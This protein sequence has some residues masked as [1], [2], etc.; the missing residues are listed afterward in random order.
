M[1][2]SGMEVIRVD[3]HLH[4]K[5]DK[6]FKYNGD[7]NSF[8]KDYVRKLQ[9]SNIKMTFPPKTSPVFKL[10]YIYDKLMKRRFYGE[11]KL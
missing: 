4:T 11:S 10:V 9:E 5:F 3:F 1:F 7:D 8:I 6:G 2:E